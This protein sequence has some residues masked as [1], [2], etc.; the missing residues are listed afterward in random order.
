QEREPCRQFCLRTPD[1]PAPP[2]LEPKPGEAGRRRRT[3]ARRRRE[4]SPR[5]TGENNRSPPP[6]TRG[7]RPRAFP[8]KRRSFAR[9]TTYLGY[10]YFNLPSETS[11]R[12]IV[13]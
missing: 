12:A 1:P 2:K 7:L 13:R 8:A 10:L 6:R 3:D 5:R 4:A 9:R 11:S